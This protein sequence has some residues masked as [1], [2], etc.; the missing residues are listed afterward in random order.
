M[1]SRLNFLSDFFG[2]KDVYRILFDVALADN[3]KQLEF[4][5]SPCI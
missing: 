5:G 1:K 4:T 2:A 3:K